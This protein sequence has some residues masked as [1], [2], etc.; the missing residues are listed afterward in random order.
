[1]SIPPISPTSGPTGFGGSSPLADQLENYVQEVRACFPFQASHTAHI[2]GLLQKIEKFLDTNKQA[3]FQVCNQNGWRP[4]QGPGGGDGYENFFDGAINSINLF[5]QNPNGGTL[6][7]I[8]EQVTEL[9]WF[10][11]AQNN[12]LG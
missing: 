7:M 3:I 12:S 6:D 5:L 10:M 1:M 9:H 8:N 4:S 11:T 2:D